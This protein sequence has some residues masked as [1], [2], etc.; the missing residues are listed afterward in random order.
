MHV[1]DMKPVPQNIHGMSS[2]FEFTICLSKLLK[3]SEI[4]NTINSRHMHVEPYNPN[5]ILI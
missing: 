5:I 2:T 4:I 3:T 1:Y